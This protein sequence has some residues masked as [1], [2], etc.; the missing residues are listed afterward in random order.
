[1]NYFSTAMHHLPRDPAMCPLPCDPALE[2][3]NYGVKTLQ[4]VSHLN[5]C[6]LILGVWYCASTMRKV[7][8]MISPFH[9]SNISCLFFRWS[10]YCPDGREGT[11]VFDEQKNKGKKDTSS[12]V[13][14]TSSSPR[15]ESFLSNSTSVTVTRT[16]GVFLCIYL[17]APMRLSILRG[18]VCVSISFKP[19]PEDRIIY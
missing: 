6:L 14:N 1:M 3:A 4:I 8:K 11:H 16:L 2:S 12:S 5:L 19:L 13:W 10:P 17:R 15:P 7:T 9:V 18:C